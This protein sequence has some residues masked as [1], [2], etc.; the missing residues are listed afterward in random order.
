[1]YSVRLFQIS[2]DIHVL[3]SEI[4]VHVETS[5]PKRCRRRTI[6]RAEAPSTLHEKLASDCRETACIGD[7]NGFA[8]DEYKN[9]QKTEI[10]KITKYELY[11][12]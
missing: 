12:L 11:N 6:I 9:I 2:S 3:V 10:T 4:P 7:V 1:M 8:R 5:S